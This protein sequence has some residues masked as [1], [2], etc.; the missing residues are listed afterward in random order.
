MTQPVRSVRLLKRSANSL[1]VLSGSTG[2]IFF[3][4]TNGSLRVYTGTAGEKIILATRAWVNTNTGDYTSLTNKPVLATVATSGSYTDLIN[5]PASITDISELTDTTNLLFDGTYSSLTGSP[6]IPAALTDLGITDGDATQILTT[7]GTGNF[8]FQTAAAGSSYD[9]DLN[10]TDDVQFNSV[11]SNT[12]SSATTITL[13]SPD[14]TTI[15]NGTNGVL[16]DAGDIVLDNNLYL[17]TA[18]QALPNPAVGNY[19]GITLNTDG[20]IQATRN[21]SGV[22][23]AII[24]TNKNGNVGEHI[25]IRRPGF[26]GPQRVGAIGESATGNQLG[27]FNQTSVEV[28]KTG[29]LGVVFGSYTTTER[30]LATA[31]AGEVIFNTT[32]TKLQVWTGAAWADLN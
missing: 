29:E 18:T 15:T 22:G 6:T 2:E 14:G 26:G 4:E 10:T 21:T 20:S 27:I 19:V 23:N 31:T 24:Y 30:N 12:V 7:D 8:S 13:E 17:G 11:T 3:D 32:D 5:T 9:Q 28:A 16:I 1:D 25:Q